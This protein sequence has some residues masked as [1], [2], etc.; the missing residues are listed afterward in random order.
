MGAP[1]Y[2]NQDGSVTQTA[3][4]TINNITWIDHAQY[5][6]KVSILQI[7]IHV[8]FLFPAFGWGA[9]LLSWCSIRIARGYWPFFGI[10]AIEDTNNPIKVYCNKE[11]KL[12][13]YCKKHRITS[14]IYDSVQC[15]PTENYPVFVLGKDGSYCLY[16]YTQS[17]FFFKDSQKISYLGNNVVSVETKDNIS[18]YSVIG[19]RL[20]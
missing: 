14:A 19:M 5:K 13:L 18:K 2:I 12:G 3:V 1:F 9:F 8:A 20:G 11:G 16:N 10:R 6:G 4:K 17:K 7:L 15:L